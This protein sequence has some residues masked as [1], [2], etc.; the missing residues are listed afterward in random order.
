MAERKRQLEAENAELA[1]G[2][3]GLELRVAEMSQRREEA[4]AR[5]DELIERVEGLEAHA[6]R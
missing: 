6:G 3:R 2:V 5:L 4:I 1:K